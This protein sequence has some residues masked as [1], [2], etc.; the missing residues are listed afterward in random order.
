MVGKLK[1]NGFFKD[2]DGA[3]LVTVLFLIIILTTLG[4]T[5]TQVSLNQYRNSI[6][7][8]KELAAQ[9]IAKSGANIV[10]SAIEN[11]LIKSE[12]LDKKSSSPT[13]LS[14]GHFQV[15]VKDEGNKIIINSLG[16]VDNFTSRIQLELSK[17]KDYF[18]YFDYAAFATGH[19]RM[20]G[21]PY[22]KGNVGTNQSSAG[23]IDF[24]GGNPRF[25][26]DIFIGPDGD[27]ETTVSKPDWYKLES[28]IHNLPEELEFP[29]PPYPDFPDNLPYY[30]GTYTAGWNPSPPHYLYSSGWFD[31]I[32]VQSELIINIYDEDFIIRANEFVVSGA[33]KVTI[34]KYGS[35]K[36]ILYISDKFDLSGSGKVNENGNPEDV[37]L[38][39]SGNHTLNPSGS[40]KFVSNVYVEK[41]DI[42]ISG[43]G[44]ITGNIISGGNN[45]IISGDASA[46]VRALYAPNAVIKYTGSGKTRGAV[47]GKDIEMSGGTSIIYDESVKHINPE[48]LGF[49]T[50]K[51]YRR[52]WR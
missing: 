5:I 47:I 35:G 1:N 16:I 2:E 39:Y 13:P 38:Y 18:P 30:P 41:A 49:E 17:I 21:S 29:L 7:T 27:S 33:G 14:I 26:G 19:I 15:D 28:D 42:E 48:D 12:D 8:E 11:S 37:Y 22:V 44:G 50:E 3:T 31:K 40:T 46:I 24:S 9:Y 20:T 34:N 52:I 45:V 51:G 6:R 32:V 25:E 36:L 4:I 43:S 23:S 10:A